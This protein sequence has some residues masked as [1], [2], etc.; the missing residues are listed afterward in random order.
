M[1]GAPG[2]WDH[3]IKQS[4]MFGF[5]GLSRD[6]VLELKRKYTQIIEHQANDHLERH[7]VY[8]AENSRI[9]IAGLNESNVTHVAN[10]IAECLKEQVTSS[11][12]QARL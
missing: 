3:L 10:S 4:G 12:T 11:S 2:T 8:M 5:L 7:H 1:T 6:V 9:S